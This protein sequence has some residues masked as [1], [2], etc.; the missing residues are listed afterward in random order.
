MHKDDV[1]K[2]LLTE[3][4]IQARIKE[5]GEQI[6]KDYQGK[7]LLVV[8]LLKGAA[9]TVTDLTRYID[10]PLRVE[11]MVASS[12]GDGTETSGAVR[13]HLDVR[14][15]LRGKD[16]LLVD[17]I[18][19]SGVTFAA[20]VKMLQNGHPASIKTFAF[21]DKAERRIN[22]FE[23][24]Y[25]GFKIPDEFVVGYGLDYAGSYRNLPF[26]GVLKSSVYAKTK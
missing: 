5:L 23:C 6:T 17:D 7:N 2:I 4:Q 26:I 16:V 9:W 10:L 11:F 18:V 3:E 13:V 1:K 14:E 8:G 25:V 12:Y 15:D 19:D 22:G 24:D 21:C 20:I